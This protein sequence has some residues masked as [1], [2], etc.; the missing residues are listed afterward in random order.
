MTSFPE[1]HFPPSRT[2]WKVDVTAARACVGP[3]LGFSPHRRAGDSWKVRPVLR[4]GGRR[5]DV[6]VRDSAPI[7]ERVSRD[8][9]I[10]W[11]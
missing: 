1:L 9:F 8:S 10:R 11:G 4:P 7:V 3:E 6:R 2:A 5:G